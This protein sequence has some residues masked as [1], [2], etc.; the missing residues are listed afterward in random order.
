MIKTMLYGINDSEV[1]N[2][3][4]KKLDVRYNVHCIENVKKDISNIELSNNNFSFVP[5]F[6]KKNSE[7]YENFYKENFSVFNKMFLV[8][9]LYRSDYFEIENEFAIFFHSFMDI[10]IN[11]KIELIIFGA[12]PHAG[13]D[14]ILYKLAKK[15][16]LKTILFYQTIFPNKFFMLSDLDQFGK[17][18]KKV[19]EKNFNLDQILNNKNN[20]IN[21]VSKFNLQ[22]SHL[23]KINFMEF[24]KQKR[25]LKK[26]II[27]SL[28]FLKILKRI[29]KEKEFLKNLKNIQIN[30]NDLETILKSN[31]KK[32]YFPL[33]LQPEMTTSLLTKEYNDQIFLLEKLSSK[34]DDNWMIVVKENPRQSS[35]QRGK[36]FF[37]RIKYLKNVVFADSHHNSQDLIKRCDLVVTG[38]GT[39]GWEAL[40]NSKKCLVFGNPWYLNIHGCLVFNDKMSKYDIEE[41]LKEKFDKDLFID[42][43]KCL[44]KTCSEGVITDFYKKIYV[45]Y[46]DSINSKIVS[47]QVI[48]FVKTKL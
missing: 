47:D 40:L 8:R 6:T 48:K 22:N 20:Y 14:Y 23:K 11:K 42:D 3:L 34:L 30:K 32:I 21:E 28:I 19:K 5:M 37:K 9:G 2:E 27:K 46:D 35:Y 18:D 45:N 31:K 25:K 12:F 15:L 36:F 44:I 17:F 16:G 7:I 26:I 43:L 24:F 4:I 29:D 33:H 41:F 1:M 13:P 39:S 10:L 38:S